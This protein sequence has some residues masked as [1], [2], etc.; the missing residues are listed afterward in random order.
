MTPEGIK[1]EK[2][3]DDDASITSHTAKKLN[4]TVIVLLVIAIGIFAIDKF[5][6]T[7]VTSSEP[8][9]MTAPPPDACGGTSILP[10]CCS[11]SGAGSPE[12][13]PS[14]TGGIERW[15][16]VLQALISTSSK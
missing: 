4:I 6:G 5:S 15:G 13:V 11:G 12:R 8:V 7:P 1:R 9:A 10:G 3:I 16:A 2:E 14:T